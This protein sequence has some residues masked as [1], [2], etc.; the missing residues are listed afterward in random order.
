MSVSVSAPV[1]AALDVD[2]A[3]EYGRFV[4]VPGHALTVVARVP[5]GT[6][7]FRFELHPQNTSHSPG[8][9]RNANVDDT[10][11]VGYNL[12]DLRGRTPTTAR[13]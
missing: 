12:G 1:S 2:P 8:Y 10:Y 4:P 6:A 7:R 3:G 9:A 11:F 5:D 13:T